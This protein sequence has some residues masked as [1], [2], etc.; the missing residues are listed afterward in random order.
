[1]ILTNGLNLKD[2]TSIFTNYA[3][4]P[5]NSSGNFYD[6]SS[7]AL[8]AS[9]VYRAALILGQN[10]YLPYAEKSRQALSA[11]NSTSNSENASLFP[12]YA[13]FT[14]DGILFPVVDPY[15]FGVVATTVSPEGQAFVVQMH[16]AWK[17]WKNSSNNYGKQLNGC[18]VALSGRKGSILVGFIILGLI[19]VFL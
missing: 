12:S 17:D 4:R 2:N 9:T 16:Q 10:S 11:P 13:H 18:K 14:K 1:M 19:C 3:D 15:S 6:A 7:T 5:A 8:L